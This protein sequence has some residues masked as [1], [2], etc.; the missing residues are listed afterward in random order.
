MPLKCGFTW[1]MKLLI[2]IADECEVAELQ[3]VAL[4]AT[5]VQTE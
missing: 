5:F 2:Q 4:L 3:Q 1:Q